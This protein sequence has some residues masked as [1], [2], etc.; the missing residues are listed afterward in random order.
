[1]WLPFLSCLETLTSSGFSLCN[2]GL[3]LQSGSW[4]QKVDESFAGLA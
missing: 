3:Y 4:T 2:I 1:M